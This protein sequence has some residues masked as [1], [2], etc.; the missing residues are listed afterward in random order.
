MSRVL[1]K[2]D[3]KRHQRDHKCQGRRND[4]GPRIAN[5]WALGE[6]L[7]QVRPP[8]GRPREASSLIDEKAVCDPLQRLP[9]DVEDDEGN[10]GDSSDLCGG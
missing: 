4:Q 2:S 9:C 5:Q 3:P 7:N 8:R 6:I 10:E 1:T